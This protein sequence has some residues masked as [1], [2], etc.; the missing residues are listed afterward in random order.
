[1][2]QALPEV[3][4]AELPADPVARPGMLRGC[5]YFKRIALTDVDRGR[6]GAYAA[7]HRRRDLAASSQS[8]EQFLAS[9]DQQARIEPMSDATLARAAQLCQRT[10]QFNLTTKRYST[11][12]LEAMLGDDRTEIY[13]LSVSDRFGDSGITGLTILR[14]EGDEAEIDTLLMS[15]RVLGRRLEDVLLAFLAERAQA[16]G[17]RFLVGRYEPTAKNA[18]VADLYP[19]H[20]FEPTGAG[21][22]RLDI[23]LHRPAAPPETRVRIVA[24][25]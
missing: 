24:G 1:M 22:F 2:R 16:L 25:V 19:A 9:L 11:A 21:S 15:C 7:E 18:Q 4:V 20:S 8:F 12:E 3:A 13:T 14:L 5:P 17:A 6:A 10:N 23:K